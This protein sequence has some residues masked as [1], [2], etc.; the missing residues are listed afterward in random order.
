MEVVVRVNLHDLA[1]Y[2]VLF[3]IYSPVDFAILAHHVFIQWLVVS[4]LKWKVWIIARL[5]D[6]IHV[7]HYD[8]AFF[9]LKLRCVTLRPTVFGTVFVVT[10][11]C[12]LGVRSAFSVLKMDL[13]W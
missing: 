2:L 1:V 4:I 6:D 11:T 3:L 5:F 7:A 9:D 10:F 12:D 8:C 13:G